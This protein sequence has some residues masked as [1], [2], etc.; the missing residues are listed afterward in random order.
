MG[1]PFTHTTWQVK[2]GQ[3]EEFIRRWLEGPSGA[4][5]WA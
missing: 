4:T 2:P 5:G 3:E 1:A